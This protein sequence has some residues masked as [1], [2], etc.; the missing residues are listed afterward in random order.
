LTTAADAGIGA[1]TIAARNAA[2]RQADPL[3]V[4]AIFKRHVEEQQRHGLC[5]DFAE[6]A[7]C[8]TKQI[9]ATESIF[10]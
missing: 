7:R 9:C 3:T 8:G 5:C 2:V 4:I 1:Q 10:I 6:L